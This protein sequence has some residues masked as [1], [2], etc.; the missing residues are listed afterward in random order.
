MYKLDSHNISILKVTFI[1]IFAGF[2]SHAQHPIESKINI[3]SL[4]LELEK[5]Y[6]RGHINGF[7]VAIVNETETI[8]EKGFGFSDKTTKKNEQFTYF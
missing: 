6:A 7:G 8:Y 3:D 5:I 4:T 1:L 2:C